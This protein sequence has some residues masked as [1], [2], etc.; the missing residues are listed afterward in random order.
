[1]A[2]VVEEDVHLAVR[3][4][5]PAHHVRHLFLHGEVGLHVEGLS[6]R[7]LYLVRYLLAHGLSIYPL[8]IDH[9]YLGP[10]GSEKQ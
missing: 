7:G 6:A 2:G 8:V 5:R 10:L 1:M 4:H 3:L 9:Y